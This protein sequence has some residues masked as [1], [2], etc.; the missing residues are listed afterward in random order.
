[1]KSALGLLFSK[2]GKRYASFALVS[3]NCSPF[4]S[5]SLCRSGRTAVLACDLMARRRARASRRYHKLV[6]RSDLVLY[7]E[8]PDGGIV[9]I[10]RVGGGEL[11]ET[12]ADHPA[13]S[14][15]GGPSGPAAEAGGDP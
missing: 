3:P 7:R 15:K 8:P 12:V 13:P 11:G 5:A 4:P 6:M 2:P 1:M 14:V 10:S 9:K